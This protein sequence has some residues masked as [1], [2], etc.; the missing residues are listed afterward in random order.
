MLVRYDHY[1]VFALSGSDDL[2]AISGGQVQMSQTNASCP[3]SLD[4]L[5][6]TD[7]ACLKDWH[8]LPNLK[9]PGHGDVACWSNGVCV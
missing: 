7:V 2:I 4:H 3:P 8:C 6:V 5:C 9:C 1:A